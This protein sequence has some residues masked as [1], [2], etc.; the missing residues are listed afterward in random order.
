MTT[1][2]KELIALARRIGRWL[3]NRVIRVGAN[4][5][6]WYMIERAESVFTKRL[7]RAKKAGNKR[8]VRWLTGRIARWKKAGSWLVAWSKDVA[9]C[10]TNEVDTLV[11]KTKGLPLIS[12]C[13]LPPKAGAV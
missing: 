13:E 1:I 11:A 8:R 12:R 2:A 10:V 3:L 4:R 6:G 7:A 9:E 5:L